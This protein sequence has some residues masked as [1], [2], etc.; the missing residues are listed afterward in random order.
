MKA[1]PKDGDSRLR[2]FLAGEYN[3]LK[4]HDEA[5]ELI[6]KNYTEHPGLGAYQ[7][8]KEQ[9]DRTA[10]WPKWREK[11]VDFLRQRFKTDK[12]RAAEQSWRQPHQS[13]LVEILLWEKDVDGAWR[14]ANEGG[15]HPELWS[16]L[17]ELREKEHPGDALQVCRAEVKRILERTGS[18]DYAGAVRLVRRVRELMI[19]IGRGEEFAGYLAELRAVYKRKRNLMTLLDRVKLASA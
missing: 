3:R 17:A 2:E 4:R 11:A 8:L 1:F 16:K 6:W 7:P 19:R 9:S 12:R 14:E 10:Q 13:D 15:C 18:P 5:L